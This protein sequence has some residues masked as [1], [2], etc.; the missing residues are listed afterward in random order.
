MNVVIMLLLLADIF[1]VTGFG[2]IEPILA[3]FISTNLTDGTIVAAGIASTLFLLTKSIIQL[4]FSRHVDAR[5]DVSD[6]RW[7]LLGTLIIT[8][9]P[10]IY[11]FST[12]VTHMYIA[13][14]LFG[15]G[16]GLAYP[17]W[18][19]LWSTHLDKKRESF[20]WSLYSTLTGIGT[21]IAA[22]AGGFVAQY[23]GFRWTFLLVGLFAFTGCIILFV[24]LYKQQHEKARLKR[25]R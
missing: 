14:I 25:R 19:G 24:L 9:V 6:M 23:I 21:A 8:A 20:Q 1:V 22:A 4:P 12:T 17:A 11:I 15:V 3:I 7:L 13:Q 10:I 18:L 2:L 16:S 5:G